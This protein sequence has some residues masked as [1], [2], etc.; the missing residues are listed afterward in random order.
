MERLPKCSKCEAH[1]LES[2]GC[3]RFLCALC[4]SVHSM[5]RLDVEGEHWGGCACS[6]RRTCA[7]HQWSDDLRPVRPQPTE[8]YMKAVQTR[9]FLLQKYEEAKAKDEAFRRYN[10]KGK[11]TKG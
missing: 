6:D 3:S 9:E 7:H 11:E 8:L 10:P 5:P 4:G 2:D 1:H